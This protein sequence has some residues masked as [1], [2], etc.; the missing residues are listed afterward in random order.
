[1]F[2]QIIINGLI[3]ASTYALVAV[4][5][6]LIFGVMR[7]VNFAE[8]QSVMIGAFVAA[9]AAPYVGYIPAIGVAMMVNA[10]L[11]VVLER[12]AFRPFRGMELNGLIASMG[13]SII[14][15]NLAE[16]I[17]GTDPR[18]FDTALNNISVTFGTVGV[19]AQ[20]LVVIGCS[21]GLLLALWWLVQHSSLGRQFRAVSED[22]EVA[23]TMG[24]DANR[25]ARTS[26]VI[27]SSLAAA[28]G[29]LSGPVN[30]L[31]PEMGQ[32]EMLNAFAAIILGGFGNVNGTI[33]GALLIGMVQSLSAVYI[34]N[35]YSNSI[36]FGLLILTLIFFPRGL[37]PERLD[38][39]V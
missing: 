2:V 19:S 16:L 21:L 10:L 38:E 28:A 33:F 36:A 24:I 27:G 30:M 11:G 15:I 12:T 5:L 25:I 35:A 20:R 37:V 29:A 26:V 17:W 3:L 14:L 31:A 1:M 18:P 9:T 7:M 34:S 4:G 39:N 22:A 32:A 13:M 8:G 6:T 23:S